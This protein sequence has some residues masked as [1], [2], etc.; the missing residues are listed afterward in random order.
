MP[1]HGSLPRAAKPVELHR[2]KAY[3]TMSGN[4]EVSGRFLDRRGLPAGEVLDW[5]HADLASG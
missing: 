4:Y 1:I 5:T 2:A 3:A